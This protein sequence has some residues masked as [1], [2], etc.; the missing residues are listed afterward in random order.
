MSRLT[1][2]EIT[3]GNYD[4]DH[5]AKNLEIPGIDWSACLPVGLESLELP[6]A[7]L[8]GD[9]LQGIIR[10]PSLTY[11]KAHGIS[12]R[13]LDPICMDGSSL[14]Y[15]HF[16]T[17]PSFHVFALMEPWPHDMEVSSWRQLGESTP[18]FWTL[19]FPN[20]LEQTLAIKKAVS[21]LDHSLVIQSPLNLG[22]LYDSGLPADESDANSC[23][24]IIQALAPIC[25]VVNTLILQNWRITATVMDA[26]IQ[27][28]PHVSML[29]IHGDSI[30]SS[31][32]WDALV[33]AK[34]IKVLTL[35]SLARQGLS[36]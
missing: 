4:N 6:D 2:L 11:L 1:I 33:A 13:I 12:D 30:I 3:L 29:A 18:I 25:R 17:L 16:H 21:C 28:L 19:T 5:A 22:L 9:L 15:L 24:S 7:L 14:K 8:H 34:N 27:N 20:S 35:E 32:A 10:H 36:S 26:I 31:G 23:A